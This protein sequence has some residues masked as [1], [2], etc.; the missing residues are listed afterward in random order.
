MAIANLQVGYSDEDAYQAANGTVT[1]NGTSIG[2]ISTGNQWAGFIFKSL[3]ALQGAVI[4][5]AVF[6]MYPTSTA[7]DTLVADI[8]GETLPFTTFFQAT[9]NNI[10]SRPRTTAKASVNAANVG[11]NWYAVDV[12]NVVQ[13]IVNQPGWV[14]YGHVVLILDGLAGVSWQV[15]AYDGSPS[16][17]AKLDIDYTTSAS[18]QP[19]RT[20]H[21]FAQRRVRR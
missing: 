16:L 13:E 17:A 8:Y 19:P 5:S 11:A 2:S 12:T 21:Q 3:A 1:V 18:G 20:M 10:S 14:P 9:T 15:H 7:N 4:N 6:S